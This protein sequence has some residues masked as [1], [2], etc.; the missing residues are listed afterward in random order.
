MSAIITVILGML[1]SLIVEGVIR[2]L[3]IITLKSAVKGAKI[4]AKSTTNTDIDDGVVEWIEQILNVVTKQ[5][6]KESE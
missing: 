2:Q 4:L 6:E 5:W 3:V 1:K